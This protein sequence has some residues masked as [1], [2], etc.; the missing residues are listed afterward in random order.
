MCNPM[1]AVLLLAQTLESVLVKGE[2]SEAVCAREYQENESLWQSMSGATTVY[3]PLGHQPDWYWEE[4]MKRRGLDSRPVSGYEDLWLD[5]LLGEAQMQVLGCGVHSGRYW[6]MTL[7][8]PKLF[9]LMVM[10][11]KH[12]LL[13][14]LS[15]HIAKIEDHLQTHEDLPDIM[16]LSICAPSSC[17]EQ[18]L[19]DRI[20]PEHFAPKLMGRNAARKLGN[21]SFGDV[22][23]INELQDWSS[24]D[25]DFAIGGT[26][27]CGT[28]SLHK[29]LGKHP[30]IVF[31]TV[32][33]EFFFT[34]D[35]AHR[36]LPLK[37]QVD[38]YNARLQGIK[39]QKWKSAGF[40]PRLVGICNP[41]IFALGLA[42]RKLAAILKLKM[43]MILCDP[44]GRVEKL[45][46]EYHY[47]FDD[48]NDAKLRGLAAGRDETKPCLPS[49]ESLLSE[50]YGQ[51]R[52]FWQNRAVATHMP[53]MMHLFSGRLIFVHQ[54][55]L[56][57]DSERVFLSLATF[58]GVTFS[59]GKTSFLRYNSIGGNRTDLCYNRSLIRALQRHLEPEYHMQEE[60]LTQAR[61]SIPDSLRF[62][63]TRC[64]R[65]AEEAY[66]PSRTACDITS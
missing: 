63:V 18:L 21:S 17:N 40:Q 9:Q 12:I 56:R 1:A 4:V 58:L 30:E 47:C 57:E 14:L 6:E 59:F 37:S 11:S 64:D 2:S 62:R 33:E 39:E 22:L 34:A 54:E 19:V 51:L 41:T 31:S 27:S 36:L 29:N 15:I 61:E 66:C 52:Q 38:A 49:A 32:E 46:M 48:L 20:F 5:Q 35:L 53:A 44:V 13:R 23:H 60:I 65:Q 24:I 25:I 43:I 55:Q 8:I 7:D 45:F 42:R 10:G 3:I 28:S 16:R 50:R 26:D